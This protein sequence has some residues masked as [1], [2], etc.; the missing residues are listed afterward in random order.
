MTE[1][2]VLVDLILRKEFDKINLI[3]WKIKCLQFD[4]YVGPGPGRAFHS[5]V[6]SSIYIDFNTNLDGLTF[7]DSLE[8]IYFNDS[9]NQSLDNVKFPKNL[10]VLLFGPKFNQ[11]IDKMHIPE[12]LEQLQF[13]DYFD[14]PIDNIIFPNSLK[15]IS[16]GKN[17]SHS[18]ANAKFPNDTQ[19]ILYSIETSD[20]LPSN[21]EYLYVGYINKPLLNLPISLKTLIFY[22]DLDNNLKKSKIPFGCKMYKIKDRNNTEEILI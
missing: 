15:K 19:I 3:K 20:V 18:L 11:N 9:F 16:F 6:D 12:S 4:V 7:P 5:K 8:H 10:K 21:I 1:G 17:F 13:G 14:Q 22:C 2:Q